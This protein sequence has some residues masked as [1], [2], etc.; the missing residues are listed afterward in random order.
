M[1]ISQIDKKDS[2]SLHRHTLLC[3]GYI[4]ADKQ[5]YPIRRTIT[6]D[7]PDSDLERNVKS[8][9][10]LLAG[11]LFYPN[12]SVVSFSEYKQHCEEKN[13]LIA[14]GEKRIVAK[15]T[16]NDL[17]SITV[18][19]PVAKFST[20]IREMATLTC[21]T[22]V[23][24][25]IKQF[26]NSNNQNSFFENDFVRGL[27]KVFDIRNYLTIEKMKHRNWTLEDLTF[28]INSN[29]ILAINEQKLKNRRL[30]LKHNP[31]FK[32]VESGAIN[33]LNTEIFARENALK[34]F[35][36]KS[37]NLNPFGQSTDSLIIPQNVNRENFHIEITVPMGGQPP[38]R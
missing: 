10:G 6:K 19:F 12:S 14:R 2:S 28:Y 4:Q 30:L 29:T 15:L 13:T 36:Y 34:S 18:D 17:P 26:V 7:S 5:K 20:D 3:V 22:I 33:K 21:S 9:I 37:T 24:E 38:T 31:S 16:F 23:I 32:S 27:A 11:N 35:I 25:I 1:M 8:L